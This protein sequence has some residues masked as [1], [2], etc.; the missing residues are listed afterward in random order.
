MTR[1][2][3]G[4]T[5]I[6]SVAGCAT[7]AHGRGLCNLHYKRQQIHGDPTVRLIR[8]S[9]EG[10]PHID[11]YWVIR[12]RLRHVLVAEKALG[13]PLPRGAEVHHF[14]EDRSNDAPSN[15]VICPS[16]SYHQ[17]LHRRQDALKACGHAHWIH[18]WLCGAYSEPSDLLKI[19]NAS[20]AHAACQRAYKNSVDK[21]RLSA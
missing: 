11:G 2:V 3:K 17:L 10:T 5:P 20:Y 6:C 13:R 18:C 1:L 8:E 16:R 19:S 4:S 15:L 12:G 9:G 21:R 7:L 14:D